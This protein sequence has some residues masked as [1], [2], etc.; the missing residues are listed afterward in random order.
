MGSFIASHT[1]QSVETGQDPHDSLVPAQLSI[2]EGERGGW[3]LENMSVL[4]RC[5]ECSFPGDREI[6]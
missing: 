1:G 3:G 2:G 4:V 6:G 5:V